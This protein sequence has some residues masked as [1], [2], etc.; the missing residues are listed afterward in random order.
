MVPGDPTFDAPII[1]PQHARLDDRQS[2]KQTS[3]RSRWG[4]PAHPAR[5]GNVVFPEASECLR[6]ALQRH[7]RSEASL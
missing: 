6:A 3:T 7:M 4:V 1:A 2:G 5:A